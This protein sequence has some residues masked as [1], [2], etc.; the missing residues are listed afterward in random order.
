MQ[1]LNALLPLL[2]WIV[3]GG[4]GVLA[5]LAFDR[6]RAAC[7]ASGTPDW[8]WQTLFTARYARYINVALAIVFGVASASLAAYVRGEPVTSAADAMLASMIA[9]LIRHAQISLP[10]TPLLIRN[11]PGAEIVED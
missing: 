6:I 4:F 1:S 2:D 3:G 7:S 8:I 10:T 9:S 5:S 11:A